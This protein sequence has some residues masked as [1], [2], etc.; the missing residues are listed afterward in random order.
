MGRL[1]G[2]DFICYSFMWCLY[3]F[4]P[5]IFVAYLQ[6]FLKNCGFPL[7]LGLPGRVRDGPFLSSNFNFLYDLF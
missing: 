1:Y 2:K 4:D 7:T 6:R 5:M 3:G